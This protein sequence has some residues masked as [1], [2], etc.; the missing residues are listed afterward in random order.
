MQIAIDPKMSKISH[1]MNCLD[2][3]SNLVSN[4]EA[5]PAM[6]PSSQGCWIFIGNHRLL[7]DQRI[8]RESY[9]KE[10]EELRR[11]YN[12]QFMQ[13]TEHKVLLNCNFPS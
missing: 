2:H 13:V 4:Q 8:K 11:V 3:W 1:P 6:G 9:L 5:S 12:L 10:I 7:R